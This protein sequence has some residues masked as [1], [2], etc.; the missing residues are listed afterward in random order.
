M[1]VIRQAYLKYGLMV[2]HMFHHHFTLIIARSAPIKANQNTTHI[3]ILKKT[4]I[5]INLIAVFQFKPLI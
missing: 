1:S 5:K 3:P 4:A 2:T